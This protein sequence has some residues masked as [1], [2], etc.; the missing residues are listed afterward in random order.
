M[1]VYPHYE[2]NHVPGDART[3][4]NWHSNSQEKKKSE[5]VSRAANEK[6]FILLISFELE[7]DMGESAHISSKKRRP[8]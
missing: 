6:K 7:I 1:T 5:A 3:E 8:R 4:S 2:R